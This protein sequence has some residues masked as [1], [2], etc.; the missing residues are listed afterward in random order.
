VVTAVGAETRA[1]LT[2]LT[3]PKRVTLGGLRAWD[4]RAGGRAIT[5]V[6]AGVGP[7]R[8]GASVRAV[9]LPY[10][11]I[12]S[13]GFA[14]GLVTAAMPGDVVLPDTVVWENDR[15]LHHYS[16]PLHPWQTA[17]ARLPDSLAAR[18]LP[19]TLLSSA[20]VVATPDAKRAAA[21]RFGAVAVEME[22]S[23]LVGVARERGVALLVLRAILDTVDVSL[24]GLPSNLDSSWR[25]RAQLVGRPGAWPGVLTLTRH[26]PRVTR[27]L[28]LATASVLSAL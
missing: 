28:T 21:S 27:T 23:A 4:A 1:V 11:L 18:H 10:D 16:V 15:G 12:V 6:Q 25:A 17:R 22:A 8:A 24:E 13:I 26:I 19:G 20:V 2:A 5:L 7:L 9:P 3:Q 14:G